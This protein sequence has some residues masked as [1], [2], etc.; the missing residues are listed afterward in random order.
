MLIFKMKRSAFYRKVFVYC[1]IAALSVLPLYAHPHMFI[2]A[3]VEFV[4]KDTL[5]VGAYQTWGFDRFFS[6]D[7]I[8]GFDV[9][10]DGKFSPAETHDVY[11]NAFVHVK[12]YYYFTFIREGEKRSNPNGVSQFSVSNNDGIVSYRFYTDLSA[13]KTHSL[14]FAVYDYTFY[15]DFRY[16]EANPV[17]FTGHGKNIQPQYT[18]IQNK[19]Y[20]VYY[21]PYDTADMMTVYYQWKPGLEVYYPKEILLTY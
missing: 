1:S 2:T 7:I 14:Y 5:L 17:L 13:Y 12:N 3:Q 10:N 4:W 9:N 6:A 11:E 15:C 19:N 8:Q 20:P 18:I 21:D 16:K